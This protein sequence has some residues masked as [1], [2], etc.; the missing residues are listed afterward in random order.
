MLLLFV[1]LIAVPVRAASPV[2]PGTPALKGTASKNVV[3]LTWDSVKNARGYHIYLYYSADDRFKRVANISARSERKLV[4]KGSLDHIYR[5]KIRAYN[6]K[7][8]QTAYSEYSK[9]LVMKTAPSKVITTLAEKRSQSGVKISWNKAASADG[10]QVIRSD[11]AEGPYKRIAVVSGNTTFSYTD[12]TSEGKK[13]FYRVRAYCRNGKNVVYG[14]YSS[15][16]ESTV[17]ELI[18]VGD[19]RTLIMENAV[20]KTAENT[21]WICKSGAHSKWL[22][23]TAVPELN[24]ILKKNSDIVIW[25]GVN[26]PGNVSYYLDCLN[27]EIPGWKSHGARVYIMAAGQVDEDPYV[28]NED[29][30]KFNARMRAEIKGAKYIDLYTWL[31]R[32]VHGNYTYDGVHYDFDLSKKIYEYMLKNIK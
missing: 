30:K 20:G 1:M 13:W 2:K 17:R 5:Y 25:M 19:S 22:R 12:N 11:K 23:E 29:I 27:S 16:R 15:A 10:Y 14:A 6:K 4:L 21:T 7:G 9:E 8:N 28:T 24:K 32:N 3:T 18:I 31:A 26:D